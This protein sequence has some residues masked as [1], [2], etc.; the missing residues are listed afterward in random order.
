MAISEAE[1][2][3]AAR[4]ICELDG[5]QCQC[6]CAPETRRR[7]KHCE[8]P[9]A[10][11]KAALEAAERVRWQPI[12]TAPMDGSSFLAELCGNT[13]AVVFFDEDDISGPDYVWRTADGVGY[14]RDALTRWQPLPSSPESK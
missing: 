8:G 3:A 6:I 10:Q 2:Q 9:F 12:E 11:A 7:V 14:H 13:Y 5:V 4:A 1:I